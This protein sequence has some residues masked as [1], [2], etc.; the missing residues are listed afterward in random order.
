MMRNI[1]MKQP[2]CGFVAAVVV[3]AVPSIALAQSTCGPVLNEAAP[4][5]QTIQVS[6]GV[7]PTE[8]TPI[9]VDGL[10][11]STLEAVT[12]PDQPDAAGTAVNGGTS[13]VLSVVSPDPAAPATTAT[14]TVA[15]VAPPPDPC[16][17]PLVSISDLLPGG[18][19]VPAG[20]L[21]AVEGVGFQPNAQVLID[22]IAIESSSWVDSSH[23]DVVTAADAQLDGKTVSVINSDGSGATY[24]TYLRTTDLGKSANPLLAATAPIFPVQTLSNAVL[25]TP[26][27]GTFFGV[28]LQNP[29]PADSVVSIDLW[30]GGSVV[31]SASLALPS[32]TKVSRAVSELFP[33]VTPGNGSF[34]QLTATVPVQMVGLSGNDADGSVTP[35]L[36]ALASP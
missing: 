10:S 13:L 19:F 6:I 7:D 11:G 14:V 5:D 16:Q 30:D 8:P 9:I 27:G 15:A 25:A 24:V 35:V 23:I 26:A 28:A 22:G 18:G 3:L 17:P 1:G 32:L 36:P 20:S 21:V 2:A 34:F 12:L 33:D 4:V 29:N 31:A